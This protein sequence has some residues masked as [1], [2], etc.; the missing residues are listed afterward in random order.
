MPYTLAEIVRR[1][2]GELRGDPEC[3][4]DDVGPL[5]VA[6]SGSITF[7]AN[8]KHRGGLS[9]TSAA[10]VILAPEFADYFSGNRVITPNPYAYFAKVADLLHPLG[11][12]EP[13]RHAG[14]VVDAQARVAASA[15]IGPQ[16]VIG[17]GARI[18]ERAQIG[19]GCW[20]GDG[21]EIGDDVRLYAN[22]SVYPGC[23]I[24]ARTVV[25]AGAV[26]GADGFGF[27]REGDRWL[28]I[29]QLGGVVIGEDVSIGANTTIDRGTFDDTVIEDGCILDNLIQIAH[30][31][32]LGQATAMAGCAAVAGSTRIGKRCTFAGRVGIADHLEIADDVHVAATSLVSHSIKRP[33][34]Y[35]ASLPAEEA[36]QWNKNVARIRQL[37][38]IAR[39]LKKLEQDM[40]NLTIGSEC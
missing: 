8:A 3:L 6:A 1:F 36:R 13:G 23:R 2:G 18:G 39:R 10:A 17:S 7:L 24:G 5:H 14:A 15:W 33:G 31:V 40:A 38:S 22:V 16:A 30:N 21:C 25:H 35:S 34:T 12:H 32:R 26:I 19:P 29:P 27:A 11:V 28:R 37:D 9:T 4:I 20:V